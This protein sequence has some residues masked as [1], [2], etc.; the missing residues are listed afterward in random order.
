[1]DP[2]S[3]LS[4]AASV[5]QFL[6][7]GAKLVGTGLE[8]YRTVEGATKDNLETEY[9]VGYAKDLSAGLASAQKLNRSKSLSHDEEKLLELARRSH[10]LADELVSLLVSLRSHGNHGSWAAVQQ[11]VRV[12]WSESKIAS[13]RT[14]L[15]AVKT[16]MSLQ[17]LCMMR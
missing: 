4:I 9:L 17:L 12:K 2:L 5:V 15:D 13:L 7:F 6:D 16:E 11:A 8:T 10:V 1:M 3:A 14:R